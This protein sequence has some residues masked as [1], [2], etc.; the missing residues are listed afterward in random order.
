[1]SFFVLLYLTLCAGTSPQLRNIEMRYFLP[2][3][4]LLLIPAAGLISRLRR[5][6][7]AGPAPGAEP[8]RAR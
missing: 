1:L 3:D 8:A 5:P 6:R 4:V 2:A 7:P